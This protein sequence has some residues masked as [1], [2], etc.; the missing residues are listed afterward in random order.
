MRRWSRLPVLL[1]LLLVAAC[2]TGPRQELL[3]DDMLPTG[4]GR[5]PLSPDHT[6]FFDLDSA[7]L[8]AESMATL[9]RLVRDPAR[10]T[11]TRIDLSGHADRSGSERYNRTLSAGR[12][13][14]VRRYLVGAGVPE[15]LIATAA[16]G[17]RQV[18]VGT[19]DGIVEPQNRRVEVYLRSK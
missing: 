10:A 18:L 4:D 17:E 1:P 7:V 19:P 9:D 15:A 3:V 2:A 12:A 6:L 11:W 5:R 16:Y 13:E 14:A 8:T